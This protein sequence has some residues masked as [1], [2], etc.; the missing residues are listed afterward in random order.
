MTRTPTTAP[1]TAKAVENEKK[2]TLKKKLLKRC[3]LLV[4]K[5]GGITRKMWM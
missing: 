3:I 1:T 5:E 4:G 2:D